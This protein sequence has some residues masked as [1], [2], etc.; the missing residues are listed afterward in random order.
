MGVR[1]SYFGFGLLYFVYARGPS[2]QP[3]GLHR[4]LSQDLFQ[5]SQHGHDL[6]EWNSNQMAVTKLKPLPVAQLV[7]EIC[8]CSGKASAHLAPGLKPE[9]LL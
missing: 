6:A 5:G 4:Y 9:L 3:A 8:S 2:L 7:L 1:W